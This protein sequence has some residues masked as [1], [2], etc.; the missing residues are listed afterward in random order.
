M[1]RRQRDRH[2]KH[3]SKS[4]KERKNF[5]SPEVSQ[6]PMPALPTAPT[7]GPRR[8]QP[9]PLPVLRKARRTWRSLD[10]IAIVAG[11]VAAFVGVFSFLQ[12]PSIEGSSSGLTNSQTSLVFIV[13]NEGLLPVFSLQYICH[14]PIVNVAGDTEIT[15][16]VGRRG[17]L[18]SPLWWNDSTTATCDGFRVSPDITVTRAEMAVTLS[19]S[20][21]PWLFRRRIDHALTGIID[22]TGKIVRWVPK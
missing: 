21:F 17:E 20:G 11:L 16:S 22:Q 5:K 2:R 8:R 4:Q 7:T 14:A 12:P 1:N 15:N 13:K 6:S 3:K 19:F 18:R 10:R 9:R